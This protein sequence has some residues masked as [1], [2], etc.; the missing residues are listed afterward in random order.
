MMYLAT[1][2]LETSATEDPEE[3]TA[4]SLGF[5]GYLEDGGKNHVAQRQST[6]DGSLYVMGVDTRQEAPN[7]M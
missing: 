4:V 7:K 6:S 2:V 5:G 3:E 1:I